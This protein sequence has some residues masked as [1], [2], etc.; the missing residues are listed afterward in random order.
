MYNLVDF[1]FQAGNYL[2]FEG[3][4]CRDEGN[5]AAVHQ[6]DSELYRWKR[7]AK[8]P[9]EH[10]EEAAEAGQTAQQEADEAQAGAGQV[11]HRGNPGSSGRRRG[12]GKLATATNHG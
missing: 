3:E 2:V 8:N 1:F 9:E 11:V 10:R 7:S 6:A 4:G 12:G 5:S